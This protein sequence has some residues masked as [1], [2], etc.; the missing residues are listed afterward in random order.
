MPE[1]GVSP[2]IVPYGADQTIYLVVD[3]VAAGREREIERPDFDTVIADLL[4]GRFVAP[5]RV[6]AFNTLEHWR[7]DISKEVAD[8]IGVLCDIEGVPVPDY[9]GDLVE[10][11]A[12]RSPQSVF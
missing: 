9:V 5:V 7:K 2:P 3:C 12:V 4:A 8:E 6:I 11:G 1:I 10:S